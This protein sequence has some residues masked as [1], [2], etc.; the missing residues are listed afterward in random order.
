MASKGNLEKTGFTGSDSY[1]WSEPQKV[2]EEI[3]QGH[4]QGIFK[5]Y[6]ENKK[7]LSQPTNARTHSQMHMHTESKK[8]NPYSMENNTSHRKLRLHMSIAKC[9]KA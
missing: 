1:Y 8:A 6:T 3:K 9:Y 4:R 2:L 5:D 7:V